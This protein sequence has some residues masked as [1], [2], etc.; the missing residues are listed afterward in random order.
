MNKAVVSRVPLSLFGMNLLFCII[1]L[2]Q[3]A[4][5][6]TIGYCNLQQFHFEK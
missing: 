1:C 2:N 3:A 5:T 4:A 6:L